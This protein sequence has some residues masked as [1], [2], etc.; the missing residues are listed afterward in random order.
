M[1]LPKKCRPFNAAHRQFRPGI[2]LPSWFAD[3]LQ[4]IDKDLFLVWHP[5]RVLYDDVMNIYTGELENPRFSIHQEYGQEVWGW[6]LKDTEDAPILEGKW[7]LWRLCWPHGWCHITSIDFPNE[8]YLSLV[9]NRL[10]FQA[11]FRDK[12]GHFAYNRHF[13]EKQ[14]EIQDQ[15]QAA[16][17]EI[18][19]LVQDENK[20]LT[21]KAME[22]FDRGVTAPTNPKKE[23]I[24][25]YAGQGH[26]S[27]L[28]RPLEDHE[29]GLILPE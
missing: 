24:Q 1:K 2:D 9:L 14:G 6:V 23:T 8:E 18:F 12:Y 10:D 16:K 5:Y 28:S 27:R 25:S 15:M 7:H 17:D 11:K 3:G 29:G 21:R 20:W 19:K 4:A 13:R 26:R 22:N